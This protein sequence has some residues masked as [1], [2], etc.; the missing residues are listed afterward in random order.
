MSASQTVGKTNVTENADGGKCR[1]RTLDRCLHLPARPDSAGS[2]RRFVTEVLSENGGAPV[3]EVCTLL[4][5]E[6][7]TNAILHAAGDVEVKIAF[8]PRR[9][10]VLVSD[11]TTAPPQPRDVGTDAVSGRGLTLVDTLS[12]AWGVHPCPGGKEVWFE[13]RW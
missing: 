10:R 11:G 12:S 5:S 13:L 3:A 4:T 7:V 2:A 8:S 6:L 9:V 1:V